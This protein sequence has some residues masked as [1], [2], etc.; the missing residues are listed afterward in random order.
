MELHVSPR[1]IYL[2][3]SKIYKLRLALRA[4]LLLDKSHT[5]VCH[6]TSRNRCGANAAKLS[7]SRAKD[8][9]PTLLPAIEIRPMPALRSRK[10]RYGPER[11]SGEVADRFKRLRLDSL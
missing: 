2:S 1:L 7:E 5:T 10:A 3:E 6:E 11:T 8:E 4:V 9:T